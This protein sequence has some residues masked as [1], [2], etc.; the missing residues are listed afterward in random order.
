MLLLSLVLA[1]VLH[2]AAV[3]AGQAPV[4]EA[5]VDVALAQQALGDGAVRR[6]DNLDRRLDAAQDGAEREAV[7][8]DTVGD[9]HAQAPGCNGRLVREPSRLGSGLFHRIRF[10]TSRTKNASKALNIMF[11]QPLPVVFA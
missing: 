10:V 11:M 3:E 4:D 2:L 1:P 8:L 6:F 9:E 7:T 5:D